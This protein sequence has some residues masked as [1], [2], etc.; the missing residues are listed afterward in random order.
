MR[1]LF[2]LS[3]CVLTGLPAFA[4]GHVTV[5]KRERILAAS[6]GKSDAKL[7]RQISEFELTERL[8]EAKL[9]QWQAG[10]PGPAS[11]RSLAVLAEELEFLVPPIS[12]IPA[13]EPPGSRGSICGETDLKFRALSSHFFLTVT[14]I[15]LI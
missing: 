13:K 3:L 1:R 14:P 4:V 15:D 5:E 10:L 8:G 7:S 11:R 12:E 2:L 6:E 9:S